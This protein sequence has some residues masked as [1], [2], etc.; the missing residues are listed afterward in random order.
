MVVHGQLDGGKYSIFTGV[1]KQILKM[2]IKK[3]ERENLK[4][5]LETERN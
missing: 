5:A 3:T 1:L 4:Q 2:T